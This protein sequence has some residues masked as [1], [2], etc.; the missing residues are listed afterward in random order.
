MMRD[1]WCYRMARCMRGSVLECSDLGT[2]LA[3]PR[4]LGWVDGKIAGRS[5]NRKRRRAAH[6]PRRF[7]RLELVDRSGGLV[8]PIP[9]LN[10]C[11]ILPSDGVG[12]WNENRARNKA[13]IKTMMKT[14]TRKEGFGDRL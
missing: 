5:P 9:C 7:A 12:G 1:A 2:A 10:R 3:Q 14:R 11:L 4:G 6:T 13:R 8:I